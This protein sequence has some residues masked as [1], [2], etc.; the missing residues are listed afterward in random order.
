MLF[1]VWKHIVVRVRLD[2][3]YIVSKLAKH[4]VRWP[5]RAQ[6]YHPGPGSPGESGVQLLPWTL[7]V[8]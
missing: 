3:I 2:L 5:K 7:L 6:L 1:S 8:I 4:G